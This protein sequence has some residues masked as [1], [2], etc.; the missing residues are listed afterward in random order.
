MHVFR[1][2]LG[3]FTSVFLFSIFLFS[4][5][6]KAATAEPLSNT[7]YLLNPKFETG[8]IQVMS[9]SD[10]NTITAGSTTLTLDRYAQG[11]IP[12]GPDL[13]S[14][15]MIQGTGP[16][17]ISSDVNAT[18]LPVP[19]RFIGTQFV[20]PHNRNDHTYYILSPYANAQV[21][22]TLSGVPTVVTA[23]QG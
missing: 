23:L 13:A 19:G 3:G 18:D 5:F 9:L 12:A 6:L 16:F 4:V 10:A 20:I 17:S 11:A 7:Y 2:R 21:T 1:S 8:A 22:V 15:A 14:G